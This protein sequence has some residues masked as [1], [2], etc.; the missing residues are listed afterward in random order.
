M[1]RVSTCPRKYFLGRVETLA[2]DIRN[3]IPKKYGKKSSAIEL[4]SK[5]FVV[6]MPKMTP[7]V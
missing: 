7:N 6:R 5:Y 1:A 2:M 3:S 4:L